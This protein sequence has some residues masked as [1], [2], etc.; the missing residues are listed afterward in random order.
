MNIACAF[1][2]SAFFFLYRGLNIVLNKS[3]INYAVDKKQSI[4]CL[5]QL[6][7]KVAV[8][9]FLFT[10]YKSFGILDTF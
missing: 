3:Q 9:A 1:Q 8:Q 2:K 5:S 6:V 10:I 7:L 4:F